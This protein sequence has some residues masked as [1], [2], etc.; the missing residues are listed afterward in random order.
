MRKPDQRFWDAMIIRSWQNFDSCNKLKDWCHSEFG[1]LPYELGLKRTEHCF[2]AVRAWVA[3]YM[4]PLSDKLWDLPMN[5]HV[6]LL[7]WMDKANVLCV[8]N[9]SG[10]KYQVD[11]IKAKYRSGKA[12]QHAMFKTMVYKEQG[13]RMAQVNVV[14]AVRNKR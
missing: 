9:K 14:K 12:L 6:E 4:K 11:P 5:R 1:C 2:G 10:M 8:A 7:D 3:T 13:S